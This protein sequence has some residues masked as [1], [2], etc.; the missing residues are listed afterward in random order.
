MTR[1]VL[2]V[3]A[4]FAATSVAVGIVQY[5]GHS[6]YP[7]PT[8]ADS[9]DPETIR[10]YVETAPFMALFFVII[11]YAA[12]AVLGGFVATKIAGDSS[13]A[14]VIIL[15]A[16]F[17]LVSIYMMVTIP[18]PLWFWILGIGAWGLVFVGRNLARK[19][20]T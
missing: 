7:L 11:S 12:G 15:G 16:M 14:P 10:N 3:I 2:S 9:N 13:R 18:S 8:G 1:Q 6:I 4:G 5:I 17:T 19:K 20:M